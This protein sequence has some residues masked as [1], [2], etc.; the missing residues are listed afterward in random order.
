MRFSYSPE[1]GQLS[2]YAT[3]D[4]FHLTADVF[5]N[6]PKTGDKEYR[7][8]VKQL[9]NKDGSNSE[10][11]I[12]E[13][14]KD[15]INFIKRIFGDLCPDE[16]IKDIVTFS[17]IPKLG[18][19]FTSLLDLENFDSS[20]N[21]LE[22]ILSYAFKVITDESFDKKQGTGK[23]LMSLLSER[24]FAKVALAKVI[25]S[26]VNHPAI[27]GKIQKPDRQKDQLNKNLKTLDA[28]LAKFE[29]KYG[30]STA[31]MN[32]YYGDDKYPENDMEEWMKISKDASIIRLSLQNYDL[33]EELVTKWQQ[34]FESDL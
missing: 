8:I 13:F 15:Y 21:F 26:S 16:K 18:Y 10:V 14:I 12:Y 27:W 19:T 22:M 2:V 25:L 29:K 23:D 3:S 24:D 1:T 5:S 4:E 33:V 11:A 9:R 32:I 30:F 28:K 7:V 17:T 31:D 34:S 20:Q 6:D